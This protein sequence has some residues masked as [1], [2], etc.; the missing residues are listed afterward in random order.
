MKNYVFNYFKNRVI[1]GSS[2]RAIRFVYF[3]VNILLAVMD[4]NA[5]RGIAL[6]HFAKNFESSKFPSVF[7]ILVNDT[8]T[9][10]ADADADE[11]G[12]D[13]GGGDEGGGDDIGAAA[14]SESP[15]RR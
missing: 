10:P 13:E 6:A 4:Q 14:G 7:E 1:L 9:T 12:G 15:G 3:M 11:G 2:Q 5:A 8:S